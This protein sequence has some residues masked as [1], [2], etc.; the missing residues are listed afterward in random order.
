M[1]LPGEAKKFFM[2]SS[3]VNLRLRHGEIP[4]GPR[5]CNGISTEARFPTDIFC[6]AGMGY[7]L[8][9]HA[10]CHPIKAA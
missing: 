3:T 7:P 1:G 6:R 9:L 2:T 8:I 5:P 10:A 4:D